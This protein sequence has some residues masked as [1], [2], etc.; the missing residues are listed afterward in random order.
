LPA[1]ELLTLLGNNLGVNAIPTA[2]PGL[3]HEASS[4]E[5]ALLTR[6]DALLIIGFDAHT[7]QV[8]QENWLRDLLFASLS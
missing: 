7:L 5:S 3:V 6:F 8:V 4:L 1:D 2:T